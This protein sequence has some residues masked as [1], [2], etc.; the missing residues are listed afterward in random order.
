MFKNLSSQALGISGSQNEVIELALSFGFRG[1]D[2][3]VVEFADQIKEYGMPKARRL[4]D[5]A[6]LKIGSFPLPVD[7]TGDEDAFRRDV[8]RLPALAAA[9][10]ELGCTRTVTTVQPGCDERPYHQNFEFH[11][12]RLSEIAGK[13]ASSGIRLGLGFSASAAARRGKAFEFIHDLDALLVIISMLGVKN[14]GVNLDLWQIWASGGA[15]E[16]ARSKLKP[17][18]I[19]AVQLADAQPTP[20]PAQAAPETRMLPG[21][22]G[23]IDAIAALTMLAEMGYDGPVTPAPHPARFEGMRRDAIVKLTGEKLDAAWKGAGLTTAGRL[24]AAAG[25]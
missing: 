7:W 22:S 8:D 2:L 20:E 23:Q 15:L 4:L 1:I 11:Q 24:A 18:Q 6:K 12:K 13:L 5:S 16:A 19:V 10:A 17:E 9:A 14:V 3:D 25:R 21:E